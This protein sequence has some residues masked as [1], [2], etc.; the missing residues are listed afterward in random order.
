MTMA[1]NYG[2]C[3]LGCLQLQDSPDALP[4]APV[5]AAASENGCPRPIVQSLG[6]SLITAFR[7]AST[8]WSSYARE[9]TE[10]LHA[11]NVDY[12]GVV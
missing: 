2:L 11:F 3:A 1:F 8:G 12:R 5:I 4:H 6:R 10:M 7:R 9:W